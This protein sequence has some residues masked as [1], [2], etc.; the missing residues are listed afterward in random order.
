MLG[1]IL[2]N[3]I[4]LDGLNVETRSWYRDGCYGVCLIMVAVVWCIILVMISLV[5]DAPIASQWCNSFSPA[6][7][8]YLWMLGWGCHYDVIV[9]CIHN[10]GSLKPASMVPM[11]TPKMYVFLRLRFADY[12]NPEI[13]LILSYIDTWLEITFQCGRQNAYVILQH[14]MEMWFDEIFIVTIILILYLVYSILWF[15]GN[16]CALF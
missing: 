16:H 9:T 5:C 13:T 7:H 4:W 3:Y 12:I 10:I 1:V 14:W 11:D 8:R 15:C 2:S 6:E